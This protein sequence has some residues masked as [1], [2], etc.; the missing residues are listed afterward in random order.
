MQWTFWLAIFS[1]GLT[2]VV[3]LHYVDN[4]DIRKTLP[5]GIFAVLLGFPITIVLVQLGLIDYNQKKILFPILRTPPLQQLAA[6]TIVML[7]FHFLPKNMKWSL[8]YIASISLIINFIVSL[9]IQLNVIKF[10][11]WNY[12]YNFILDFL[13]LVTVYYFYRWLE[14]NKLNPLE[15]K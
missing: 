5:P 14:D 10:I 6:G 7:S 13:S 1:I 15:N 3:V 2:L 9:A 4:L 11:H 8:L 12:L